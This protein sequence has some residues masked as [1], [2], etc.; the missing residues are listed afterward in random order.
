MIRT[1]VSHGGDEAPGMAPATRR[2]PTR[3]AARTVMR[4]C[5]LAALLAMPARLPAQDA[6]RGGARTA[7][8]LWYA[9]RGSGD[10]VVLIHGSNLDSRSLSA[11]ADAL[12]RDHRV[13]ELDLRFHGRSGDGDGPFSFQEDVRDVLDAAGVAR[14]AIVGHS[15]GGQVAVDLALL[16]PERVSRLLLVAPG[17]SGRA[18]MRRPEGMEAMVQA[19]RAR[20]FTGAADALARL[21]VMTLYRDTTQQR[22]VRA[23]VRDNAR[24]FA[25]DPRRMRPTGA[26]AAGRLGELALPVLVVMGGADPT[27][28][29][30]VG[31]EV[32]AGVRGARGETLAGCGHLVPIDCPD[33]LIRMA[34]DFL[35]TAPPARR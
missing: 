5:A 35:G 1:H 26:P 23:M 15:L 8:G 9:V 25:A 29:S 10:A 12:A 34:R 6:A 3:R 19:L 31:R 7:S 2:G 20:D 28:S 32:V 24:L 14:A 11:L 30:D 21:P 4:W 27:E 33:D 22:L 17:L 13:I 18:A 16:A